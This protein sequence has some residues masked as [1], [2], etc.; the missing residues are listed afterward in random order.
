MQQFLL[1]INIFKIR[2]SENKLSMAAGHLTYNTMLAI[3]PLIMV[4]FS[5]FA[6]FPIFNEVTGELKTFIYQN[7]APSVGDIVQTHLDN[8]VNNSKKMSA[9]GTIGL[10]AIALLLI[11][12]IDNTL[13][14]MWH[15]TKKRPWLISFAIYWMI[16]T[17]GPLLIGVSISVSTYILSMNFMGT[18]E[19]TNAGHPFLSLVPFFITWLLFT[20]VY[21]IVPNTTVLFRHAIIGALLAAIF[22]TL[23]KQIFVWYITSFP[24]YQAIYGAL[25]VLPIM[26]VW[27]HLSWLVVLIGAQIAAVFKDLML[28]NIGTLSIE[29]KEIK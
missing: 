14:T 6:A 18:G 8:F 28:I 23:G 22:F 5:I 12:N 3:V 19:L 1:F 2:F 20:L 17:L 26:I 29:N 9:V 25:A 4:M 13:N 16:L 27:I 7:F 21:T 15:K 10:I 24:S 11:S